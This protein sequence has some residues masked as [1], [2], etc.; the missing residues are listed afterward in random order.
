M[1]V[2]VAAVVKFQSALPLKEVALA[3]QQQEPQHLLTLVE[4]VDGLILVVAVVLVV[5]VLLSLNGHLVIQ[6][7]KSLLLPTQGNLEYPMVLQQSI[8]C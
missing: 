4:V 7:I 3:A 6:L 1:P 5:R 8:T 2:V